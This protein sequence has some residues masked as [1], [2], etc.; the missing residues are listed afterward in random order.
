MQKNIVFGVNEALASE[1]DKSK[2]KPASTHRSEEIL[3][4]KKDIDCLKQENTLFAAAVEEMRL[5][6]EELKSK[7]D[8]LISSSSSVSNKKKKKTNKQKARK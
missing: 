6:N 2:R 5:Q 8:E 4:L 1:S 7:I 3:E